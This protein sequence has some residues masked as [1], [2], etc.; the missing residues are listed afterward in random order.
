MI[1]DWV[2]DE[3][4]LRGGLGP[5]WHLIRLEDSSCKAKAERQ[6]CLRLHMQAM[7]IFFK[8]NHFNY[9]IPQYLACIRWL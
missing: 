7:L 2:T 1:S 4:P 8:K 5:K 6:R 9:F 3:L